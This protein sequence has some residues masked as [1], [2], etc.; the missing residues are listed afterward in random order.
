VIAEGFRLLP[1][2][3]EPL[4]SVADHAV[5]L[6]PTPDFRR[7][8]FE[9]RGSLWTIAGKTTDPNWALHNLLE[10]DEMFT[11]QLHEQTAQLGL[12]AIQID[13]ETAEDDLTAVVSQAF[14]F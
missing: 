6:L 7:A 4:L 2:L 3:V 11:D 12:R 10:R 8:A 1:R 5:W 9:S 14:G 13:T